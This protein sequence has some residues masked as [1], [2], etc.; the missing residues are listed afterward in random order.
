M[1]SH[2]NQPI[3]NLA[4]FSL[5]LLGVSAIIGALTYDLL[6][7]NKASIGLG[8]I[9]IGVCIFGLIVTIVSSYLVPF[10]HTKT[11]LTIAK[12]P[13]FLVFT[14]SLVLMTINIIGLLI[15]LRSPQVYHGINYG[16]INRVV[17]YPTQRVIEQMNRIEAI[18]EQYPDYVKRLTRLVFDGTVHAWDVEAPDNPFHIYLPMHENYLIYL[19]QILQGIDEPYEFCRAERAIERA[20]SVCSQSAKIVTNILTR[21]KVKAQIVTLENHVVV[22]ARVEKKPETWWILDAD[23]GVVIEDDLG[24]ISKNPE[25]IRSAYA[26]QGYNPAII[27]KML[28][29][30]APE[31]NQVTDDGLLCHRENLLYLLKWLIPTTGLL[32][33]MIYFAVIRLRSKE[34]PDIKDQ[35]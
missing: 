15:P 31:G 25:I 27:E 13:S 23:F 9:Q 19:L 7:T 11:G 16:G 28:A 22:R 8:G 17:K 10:W 34:D 20:A 3:R 24:T 4:A 2:N 5:D 29:I 26:S 12:I 1:A 18:D 33:L 6:S 35:G 14:I 21:N 30:Y 32:P